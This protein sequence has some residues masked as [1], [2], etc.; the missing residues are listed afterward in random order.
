MLQGTRVKEINSVLTVTKEELIKA[1]IANAEASKPKE[2][3]A[4]MKDISLINQAMEILGL[5]KIS[6]TTKK[7]DSVVKT[8]TSKATKAS[9]TSV[10]TS[11]NTADTENKE[12]NPTKRGRKKI[13]YML[14][15]DLKAKRPKAVIFEGERHDVS[16]FR[17][18][19]KTICEIAFNKNPEAFRDLENNRDVNG[20]NHPYFSSVPDGS[21]NEAV[22]I[23]NSE[24]QSTFVDVAKLAM[25][26]MLFLRKA[27]KVLGIS[28]D[29][30]KI[31]IDPNYV[32][33]PRTSKGTEE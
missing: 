10:K 15:D 17:D 20:S 23:Q 21:M 30:V 22:E 12:S 26:N 16:S 27:L 3:E 31:E 8:S 6:R 18:M 25:N 1:M 7:A 13:S 11:K 32:R 29:S 14:S 4:V 28:E 2:V 5:H 33:K 19:T 9:K 24:G